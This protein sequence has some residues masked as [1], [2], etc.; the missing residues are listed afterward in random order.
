MGMGWGPLQEEAGWDQPGVLGTISAVLLVAL[1]A[2]GFPR[3]DSPSPGQALGQ[4]I[5]CPPPLAFNLLPLQLPFPWD[6]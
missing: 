2:R 1:R 3:I 5:P 6:P 4:C